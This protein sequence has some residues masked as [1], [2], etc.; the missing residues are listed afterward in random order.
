MKYENQCR[1]V[2]FCQGCFHFPPTSLSH[3]EKPVSH[4]VE[5]VLTW[6]CAV[7]QNDDKQ[8]LFYEAEQRNFWSEV[9]TENVTSFQSRPKFLGFRLPNH[10]AALLDLYKFIFVI[11]E[12][13][14]SNIFPAP[15]LFFQ[16][17]WNKHYC[18]FTQKHVPFLSPLLK[19][20]QGSNI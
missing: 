6:K 14:W 20:G 8:L 5:D 16:R 12:E 2:S 10:P 18:M 13:H 11:Y 9:I 4:I 17:L 19:W 15:P 1:I 7:L 3:T